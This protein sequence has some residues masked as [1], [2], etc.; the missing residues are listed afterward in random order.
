[1]LKKEEHVAPLVKVINEAIERRADGLLQCYNVTNGQVYLLSVINNMENGEC[2]L[3]E[4]EKEIS[5]SSAAVAGSVTRLEAKHYIESFACPGDK[6]VKCI[7][8][9]EEGRRILCTAYRELCRYEVYLLED[10]SAQERTQFM[11]QLIRVYD[12]T[13]SVE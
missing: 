9:T 13:I 7:R 1:M 4:L 3:K 11:A 10:F 2:T 6:R 8:I 12:K 5:F